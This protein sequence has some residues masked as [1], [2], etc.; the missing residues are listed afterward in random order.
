MA[1]KKIPVVYSGGY[2]TV[3]VDH[4]GGFKVE[5]GKD[6]EVP[7]AFAI[8]KCARRPDEWKLGKAATDVHKK[9]VKAHRDEWKPMR[10]R[11]MKLVARGMP[12][13]PLQKKRATA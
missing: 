5:R 4:F 8:E 12:T 7:A 9:E 3:N 13:I 1:E 6:T 11:E 10:D 2:S